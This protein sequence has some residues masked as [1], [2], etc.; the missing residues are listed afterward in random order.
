MQVIFTGEEQKAL[1]D[2]ILESVKN[3]Q[4]YLRT[5]NSDTVGFAAHDAFFSLLGSSKTAYLAPLDIEDRLVKP[6]I[7]LITK[8]VDAANEFN[9]LDHML[10]QA[11][12][13]LP[14]TSAEQASIALEVN[15]LCAG[16]TP[17]R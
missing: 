12:I 9:R 4:T 10:N 15:Q 17:H 7:D 11:I 6:L 3:R 1:T 16:S 14:V 2:F 5:E 13:N 8:Y